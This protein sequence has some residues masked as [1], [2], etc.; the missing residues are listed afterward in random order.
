MPIILHPAWQA[1]PEGARLG[2]DVHSMLG[3]IPFFLELLDAR[4]AKEQIQERYRYGGWSPVRGLRQIFDR[5]GRPTLCYPGDP[6]LVPLAETYLPATGERI[7]FYLHDFV[8]VLDVDGF[9]LQVARC[10]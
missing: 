8:A 10:D 4:P 3:D 6:P 2:F 5:E 7:F 1:T 9:N